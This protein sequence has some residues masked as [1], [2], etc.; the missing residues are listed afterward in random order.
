MW[1]VTM[2]IQIPLII[3]DTFNKNPMTYGVINYGIVKIVKLNPL[4][5]QRDTLMFGI[6][7]KKDVLIVPNADK[8]RLYEVIFSS[9]V[10]S[11]YN[12]C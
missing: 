12:V 1:I 7:L 6:N 4:M 10:R 2:E 5:H 3:T 9:E 8:I 11:L